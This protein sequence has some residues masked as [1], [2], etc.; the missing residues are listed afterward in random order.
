MEW[1]PVTVKE[2]FSANVCRRC[3][4]LNVFGKIRKELSSGIR[5]VEYLSL[6]TLN[7]ISKKVRISFEEIPKPLLA[8]TPNAL[9]PSV[10][11][12]F[13]GDE[14]FSHQS[15]SILR[16][17]YND[18]YSQLDFFKETETFLDKRDGIVAIKKEY[19]AMRRALNVTKFIPP[20]KDPS[21]KIDATKVIRM[22]LTTKADVIHA[23]LVGS[24][25]PFVKSLPK[26]N[27]ELKDLYYGLWKTG[28]GCPG[29]D[30]L[31]Y[32]IFL[33]RLLFHTISSVVLL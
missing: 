13:G 22:S 28:T 23:K 5:P 30:T 3:G 25:D 33:L 14:E 21:E 9:G 12:E 19:D 27:E 31:K 8:N 24:V 20:T 11:S 32:K 16:S 17:L 4:F 26:I 10:L 2:T 29:S 18:S 15:L 1:D 6:E 7:Y